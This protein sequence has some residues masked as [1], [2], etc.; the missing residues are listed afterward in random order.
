[1]AETFTL[2]TPVKGKTVSE[3]TVDEVNMKWGAAILA[4]VLLDNLGRVTHH[5][6][7]GDEACAKMKALNKANLSTKSLHRRVL[8]M[9]VADGRIDAGTITGTSD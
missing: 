8:E 3:M 5:R 6:Y 4:I 9:L 1:M 7:I 2:D